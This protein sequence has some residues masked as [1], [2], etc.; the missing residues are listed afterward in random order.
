MK[1]R[2]IFCSSEKSK[3][4]KELEIYST[5]DNQI[6]IGV[7]YRDELIAAQW[8]LLDKETAIRLSR[9]LR[10]EISFLRDGNS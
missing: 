4:R 3:H 10:R 6:S 1:V 9:I 8:I 2:T 7:S 5:E